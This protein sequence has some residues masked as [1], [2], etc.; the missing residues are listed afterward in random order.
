M[1]AGRVPGW[2]VAPL[3][4]GATAFA[5]LTTRSSIRTP[6]VLQAVGPMLAASLDGDTD[7]ESAPVDDPR[8]QLS[9]LDVA[10]AD[11]RHELGFETASLFLRGARGWELLART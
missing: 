10:L 3:P 7:V 2:I 6:A 1:L 4:T 5:R 8:P 11:L 9:G